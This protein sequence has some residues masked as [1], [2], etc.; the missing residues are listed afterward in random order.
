[1]KCFLLDQAEHFAIGVCVCLQHVHLSK[2][3]EDHNIYLVN[4]MADPLQRSLNC[5]E[6]TDYLPSQPGGATWN[7]PAGT[8]LMLLL[9]LCLV[10][11]LLLATCDA[12]TAAV[13]V[14]AVIAFA[15]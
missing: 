4:D 2:S 1:M 15:R 5:L 13:R 7:P 10:L 14:V 6:L 12:V 9:L 8:L 3:S 11:L